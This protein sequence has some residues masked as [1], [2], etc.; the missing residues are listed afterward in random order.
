MPQPD[1]RRH[2]RHADLIETQ[3]GLP[4]QRT[5]VPS[6]TPVHDWEVPLEW[7]VRDAWIADAGGRRS[8]T[9]APT[10]CT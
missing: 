1:G 10:T 2:A 9:S 5:E 7:N 8:S 4:L 6:G 3:G